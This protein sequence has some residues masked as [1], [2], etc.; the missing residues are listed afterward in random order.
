MKKIIA[1]SIITLLFGLGLALP[2]S[3]A[4]MAKADSDPDP[5]PDFHEDF[6]SYQVGDMDALSSKWTNAY[7]KHL[8][9][10][11][12]IATKDN[13]DVQAD[14]LDAT[15]KCLYVHTYEK[16]ES[17]FYN[18]M[19]DI[20]VKD[21]RLTYKYYQTA[22]HNVSPWAGFNFRKPDDGRYNGVT[23]VMMVLRAWTD[24]NFGPQMYRSVAD[25]MMNVE[26]VGPTGEGPAIGLTDVDDGLTDRWLNIKIE[27]IGDHFAFYVDDQMLGQATISKKTANQ[28]GYVSIV[29]CVCD[30]YFD[31][32]HLENLDE[33]P[34]NGGS[35]GGQGETQAPTMEVKDYTFVDG[36]DLVVTCDTHGEAITSFR[37]GAN[38]VLPQYYEVDGN[39]ITISKDYLATL[40]GGKQYFIIQTAG[41]TV[42]FAITINKSS[43]GNTPAPQPE[44]G[45][46]EQPAPAK[47]G[48]GGSVIAA[49][50]LLSIVSLTGAVLVLRKKRK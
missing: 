26:M 19:K 14:P 15:N 48:C 46:E 43:G 38:E 21:F 25:S 24:A 13:F 12:E 6:E 45:G 11:D 23:N 7:F 22:T 10:G 40:N 4:S 47:K 28:Y 34:Y 2:S 50:A 31:D 41:G 29:S 9:D 30:S 44:Q 1:S 42:S 3:Q 36:Q 16:N 20:Y 27:A 5:T 18:T 32:I 39:Q 35:G 17:F 37:Q 49:S 8:G 33:E